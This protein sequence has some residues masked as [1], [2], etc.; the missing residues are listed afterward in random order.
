M[1][2]CATV[3]TSSPGP[4]PAAIIARWSAAV[5]DPTPTAWAAPQA[6]AN[7]FSKRSRIGPPMNRVLRTTSVIAASISDW[8]LAYC[9]LR[10]QSG[11]STLP[12]SIRLSTGARPTGPRLRFTSSNFRT[13]P[14]AQSS[15]PR[16]E[17]QEHFAPGFHRLVDRVDHLE[18]LAPFDSVDQGVPIG[19]ERLHHVEI[20]LP[21]VVREIG[22]ILAPLLEHPVVAF[23]LLVENP[24]PEPIGRE[25]ADLDGSFLSIEMDAP[26]QVLRLDAGRGL[27]HSESAAPELH[28]HD[29]G[30]LDFDLVHDG[31]PFGE[32]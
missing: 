9:A 22:R 21:M 12:P 16:L 14:A 25:T 23:F 15:A 7:S 11:I 19:F 20:E 31:A 6:C 17:P 8:M 29:R 27:D 2:V 13:G 4:T 3:T 1:K 30:V 28:Q 24:R 18:R 32:D 26:L 10:S 5:P